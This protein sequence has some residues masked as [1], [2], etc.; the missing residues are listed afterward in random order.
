MGVLTIQLNL[1]LRKKRLKLL[2]MTMVPVKVLTIQLNL[3]CC[4]NKRNKNDYSCPHG[5]RKVNV[6]HLIHLRKK[7]RKR[8]IKKKKKNKKKKETK[9]IQHKQQ[10]LEIKN[11]IIQQEKEK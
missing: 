10:A 1:F 3:F 9:K 2:L 7:R 4:N 6:E 8:K 11:L 5:L